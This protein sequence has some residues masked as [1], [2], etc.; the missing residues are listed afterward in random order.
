V[1]EGLFF[2]LIILAVAVLQGIGKKKKRAG[3]PGQKPPGP[4]GPRTAPPQGQRPVTAS[5]PP[6]LASP[7]PGQEELEAES[8]EGMIPQDV[9]AEILG[10]ARGAP[11]QTQAEAPPPDEAAPVPG[12]REERPVQDRV[13]AG[14]ARREEPLPPAV[15]AFPPS[16]GA[17]AVLH[18]TKTEN[19]ESRLAVSRTPS[20]GSGP[21]EGRGVRAELF[22][23]GSPE[24]LRKAIILSEVLGPPLGLR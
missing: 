14:V 9:W 10:L 24:E 16:H 21:G 15:R 23:S 18:Q 11:R 7:R 6:T 12:T 8:S 20:S 5:S 4:P 22:G 19:F 13:A 1:D 17:N 3:Q 2:W